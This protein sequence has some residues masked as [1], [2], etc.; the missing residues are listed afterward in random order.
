[1]SGKPTQTNDGGRGR[2]RPRAFVGSDRVY[3]C[4]CNAESKLQENS[5]RRAIVNL[6][7]DNGGSMTFDEINAAFGFDLSKTVR[8]LIRIGWL[9][10][11]K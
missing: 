8:A 2:G 3:V 9:G 1:M 6:I 10:L 11:E 4:A 5:E 7:V